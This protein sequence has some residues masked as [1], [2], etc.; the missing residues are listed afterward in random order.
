M[1]VLCV[2]VGGKCTKKVNMGEG[3]QY[4]KNGHEG[5]IQDLWKD[6][7]FFEFREAYI[8]KCRVQVFLDSLYGTQSKLDLRIQDPVILPAEWFCWAEWFCQ[9]NDW[10]NIVKTP[11]PTTTQANLNIGLGLT[12]FSLYTPPTTP[13]HRN[14]TSTRNNDP[15]VWNFVGDL[16]KPN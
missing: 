10:V 12:W 8:T 16:T 6:S 4:K 9:Q 15:R 5:S 13:P 7:F 14:S 11:T 1:F 3:V 2:C